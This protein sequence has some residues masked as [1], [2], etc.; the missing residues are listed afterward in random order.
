MED[1]SERPSIL[2]VERFHAHVLAPSDHPSLETLRLQMQQR[3]SADLSESLATHLAHHL[4]A[5]DPSLWFLRRLRFSLDVGLDCDRDVS[6]A[7]WASHFSGALRDVLQSDPDDSEAVHFPSEAVYLASFFCDL[8]RGS[9]WNK[10]YYG[11]FDG[12][13]R[14]SLSAALRTCICGAPEMAF[15]GLTSLTRK[16]LMD[17][18]RSLTARDASLV[19]E[20]LSARTGDHDLSAAVRG[21]VQCWLANTQP[22]DAHDPYDDRRALGLFLQAARTSPN[23]SGGALLDATRAWLRICK[24]CETPMDIGKTTGLAGR[25]DA[26]LRLPGSAGEVYEILAGDLHLGPDRAATSVLDHLRKKSTDESTS[27]DSVPPTFTRFGGAF[28]LLRLMNKMNLESVCSDWLGIRS[29]SPAA[30]AKLA[31]LSRCFG[32][33]DSL[34]VFRDSA[35]RLVVGISPDL[36]SEEFRIWQ[37]HLTADQLHALKRAAVACLADERGLEEGAFA[38]VRLPARGVPALLLVEVRSARWTDLF[39]DRRRGMQDPLSDISRRWPEVSILYS[40]PE[41]CGI[42]R[43]A[44]TTL[45]VLRLADLPEDQRP[46]T[47]RLARDLRQLSLPI[48]LHPGPRAGF[49]FSV[50]ANNVL[51]CITSRFPALARASLRYLRENL[52]DSRARITLGD[53]CLD[54]HLTQPPLH[55]VLS[56]SGFSHCFLRMADHQGCDCSVRWEE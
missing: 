29:T 17:V 46:N 25:L 11:R 50:V 35:L 37:Q 39:K 5:E 48:D 10:W 49:A 56:T 36:S 54:V 30:L 53:S 26:L 13:R 27:S 8:V 51:H 22:I 42:G 55:L 19:L 2:R 21:V 28:L 9:A 47:S 23:L 24:H 38:L 52:L 12:L 7:A 44:V 15:A 20:S 43:T 40:E 34:E 32:K 45:Q 14:L 31:I 4:G 41:I 3:L 6:V 33:Q 1:T 18:S 16:A